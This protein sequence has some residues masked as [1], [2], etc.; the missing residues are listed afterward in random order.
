LPAQKPYTI[1]SAYRSQQQV[2][3]T[4]KNEQTM[5]VADNILYVEGEA[6]NILRKTF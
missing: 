2:A 1:K 5:Q 6:Q 4:L 3:P